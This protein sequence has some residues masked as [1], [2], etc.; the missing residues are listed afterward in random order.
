MNVELSLA[1]WCEVRLATN[2]D[3]FDETRGVSGWTFAL[4]GEPDLDRIIRFQPSDTVRRWLSPNIGVTIRSV[5]IGG[6]TQGAN[7]LVGAEVQLLDNPVFEGRNGVVAG[8]AEEPILPFHIA[9]VGANASYRRAMVDPL[10]GRPELIKSIGGGEKPAELAKAGVASAT[11]HR[12]ER[13]QRIEER[14][15]TEQNPQMKAGL[16]KRKKWFDDSG[17]GPALMWGPVPASYFVNYDYQLRGAAGTVHDPGGVLPP[18]DVNAPWR[19]QLSFGIW[20]SDTLCAYV[21]GSLTLPT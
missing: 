4:P 14:L 13:L 8:D 18:I 5:A 19:A 10:T 15:A 21:T 2:P 6:V 1:G 7:S 11:A 12:L 3:P 16:R 9:V 17:P 20:D